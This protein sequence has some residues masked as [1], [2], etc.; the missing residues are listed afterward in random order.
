MHVGGAAQRTGPVVGDQLQTLLVEALRVAQPPLGNA[1]VGHRDGTPEDVGDVADAPH[2][3]DGVGVLGERSVEVALGPG[4]EPEQCVG[5]RPAPARRRPARAAST[6]RAWSTVPAMSPRISANAARYISIAPG[7]VRSCASS[8]T[9]MPAASRAAG[10]SASHCSASRR[11]SSTRSSS[12]VDINTPTNP[13][14]STGRTRTTCSGM[15]SA[16]ARSVA[17]CRPRRTAGSANSASS[18]ARSKSPAANACRIAFGRLVVLRE[19]RAGPAMQLGRGIR[20]FVEEPGAQHVGEEVVVPVPLASIV[21]RDHEQVLPI[22]RLERRLASRRTRDRVAQR[23]LEAVE[24]RRLQHEPPHGFGLA[25]QHFARQVVDDEAIVAG[26]AGDEVR[27]V[28]PSLHR[29]RRELQRGDPALGARFQR[30]D[31]VGGQLEAHRAVQVRRRLL[32]GEAQ[33]GGSDLHQFAAHSQA[34]QRQRRI[35]PARQHEVRA[36]GQVV[37]EVGHPVPECRGDR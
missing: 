33:I 22:Q 35:G 31:V 3:G 23:S 27:D 1:D 18:A 12:P 36:L 30:R 26:K 28:F 25:L 16:H 24:D 20:I 4:R 19:P 14:A 5:G 37:E 21:E 9:I 11:C 2:P 17:S 13:T 6:R 8:T 34:R 32:G 7:N 15:S 10:V 29:Q